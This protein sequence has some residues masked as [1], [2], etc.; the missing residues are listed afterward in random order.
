MAGGAAAMFAGKAP[1]GKLHCEW[2]WSQAQ[3]MARDLDAAKARLRAATEQADAASS[4][5]AQQQERAESE[6]GAAVAAQRELAETA[7]LLAEER[8]QNDRLMR[9]LSES[10][11]AE[12]D[13]KQQLVR[14][15]REVTELLQRA[16]AS[17]DTESPRS[18][19]RAQRIRELEQLLAGAK[20]GE[21]EAEGRHRM[22]L[23]LVDNVDSGAR[24]ILSCLDTA[25]ELEHEGGEGEGG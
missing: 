19:E 13:A 22:A 12:A 23:A 1:C 14:R 20:E 21:R 18:L 15:E 11:A 6:G 16:A 17:K 2:V 25:Y 10:Q 5:A 24:S 7:A 3:G 8:D 9:L 4:V